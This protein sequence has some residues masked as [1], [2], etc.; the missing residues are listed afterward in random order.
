MPPGTQLA[1]TACGQ[2]GQIVTVTVPAPLP[3][4]RPGI[5]PTPAGVAVIAR[6]RTGPERWHCAACLASVAVPAP[7]QPPLGW[8][9]LAAGVSE[10]IG[11]GLEQLAR[12]CSVECLARTLP[13]VADRMT[14]RPWQPPDEPGPARN[15]AELMRQVPARRG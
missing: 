9:A 13:L 8:F 11:S 3:S 1:C 15:V 4:I 2:G 7:G 10:G 6:R 5:A 14:G 12:A